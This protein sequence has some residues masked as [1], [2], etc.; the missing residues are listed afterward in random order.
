MGLGRFPR[1]VRSG[2][3]S[4][5][6]RNNRRCS[7]GRIVTLIVGCFRVGCRGFVRAYS[8]A[9]L[10]SSCREVLTGLGRPIEIVSN[11]EDFRKVYEKVSRGNRLLIRERGGRIIGIDTKRISIHKLCDCMWEF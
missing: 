1:R 10:L 8:F 7:E 4:L 11:S 6:L 3:A 9:R 5:V 2:T